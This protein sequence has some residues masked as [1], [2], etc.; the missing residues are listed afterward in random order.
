M[1][2]KVILLII[3]SGLVCCKSQEK[4]NT[5]NDLRSCFSKSEIMELTKALDF[6]EG[7][8]V[9]IYPNET[10]NQAYLN[11]INDISLMKIPLKRFLKKEPKLI[12]DKLKEVGAFDKIWT[13]LSSINLND[14]S[15]EQFVEI[16]LD[17]EVISSSEGDGKEDL[18]LICLNPKGVYI[19]CLLD[20]KID[21]SIIESLRMQ[22]KSNRSQCS[23]NSIF[24]IK[25]YV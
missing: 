24:I 19:N 17:G 16:N 14:N 13:S 8:L 12:L 3:F 21:N 5:L 6:F 20:K 10:K 2:K 15:D 23:S 11:Y 9:N 1:I 22:K 4:G 18:D 7:E 25:N